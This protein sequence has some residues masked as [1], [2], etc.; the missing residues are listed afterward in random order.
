VHV[1]SLNAR[2]PATLKQAIDLGYQY[3]DPQALGAGT[4]PVQ[5]P[6]YNNFGTN[7][8]FLNKADGS[9]QS[10][11]DL[12]HFQQLAVKQV[13]SA[14]KA[15][16]ATV[17]FVGWCRM[18][19]CYCV[20]VHV[21]PLSP[22]LVYWDEHAARL[23]LSNVWW[24]QA[25]KKA[26]GPWKPL[27]A[28][29]LFHFKGV[30]FK[31]FNKRKA[32][33]LHKLK[34]EA[35]LQMKHTR[36][37]E[38][39]QLWPSS[40]IAGSGPQAPAQ[41]SARPVFSSD[42]PTS[43]M[44]TNGVFLGSHQ[45]GDS[46]FSSQGAPHQATAPTQRRAGGFVSSK[47]NESPYMRVTHKASPHMLY[48][49]QGKQKQLWPSSVIGQQPDPRHDTRPRPWTSAA[50][51]SI[52]P[53]SAAARRVPMQRLSFA[54]GS[55]GAMQQAP[56]WAPKADPYGRR[57]PFTMGADGSLMGQAGCVGSTCHW[58]RCPLSLPRA[59]GSCIRA[60]SRQ[61]YFFF[62]LKDMLPP[63]WS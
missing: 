46:S 27:S 7:H 25:K 21:C 54:G 37:T 6:Q 41:Q 18:L 45:G 8:A 55:S 2:A 48:G 9:G 49:V 36:A 63:L 32:A 14:G 31:G 59:P 5:L 30:H 42:M 56:S 34:Q 11:K 16:L 20:H 58:L 4:H 47:P 38:P 15:M 3:V 26:H 24:K 57:M 50:D 23:W 10:T 19:C 29:K 60:G 43:P 1:L 44:G 62:I 53:G 12:S 39:R 61:L 52:I 33:M 28:D 35:K 40:V 17:N 51:G 13:R 22:P